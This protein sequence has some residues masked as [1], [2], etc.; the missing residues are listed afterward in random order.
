[1][2]MPDERTRSLLQAGAFLKELSVDPSVPPAMRDEA[3][4][5]LRHYPTLSTIRLLASIEATRG[6]NI[7]AQDI[8][9]SWLAQ[10][11]LGAHTG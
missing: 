11:R 7:L 10:Y 6:S 9:P 8:D 2:T 1:M 4:R 3:S 5:L